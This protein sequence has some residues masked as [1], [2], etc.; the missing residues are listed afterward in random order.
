MVVMGTFCVSIINIIYRHQ[1]HA[2]SVNYDLP[3]VRKIHSDPP[4]NIRLHLSHPPVRAFRV[5]Y[6]HSRL[7]KRIYTNRPMI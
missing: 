4:A 2:L 7:K 5:T 6:Q 3:C 1:I